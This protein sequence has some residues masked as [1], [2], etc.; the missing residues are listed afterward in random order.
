MLKLSFS[1]DS[2]RFILLKILTKRVINC[3]ILFHF[4]IPNHVYAICWTGAVGAG[5]ALHYSSGSDQMVQLLAAPAPQ[6]WLKMK[7]LCVQYEKIFSLFTFFTTLMSVLDPDLHGSGS[8]RCKICFFYMFRNWFV[9][10]GCFDTGTVCFETD[11][12][13][14]VVSKRVKN[15]K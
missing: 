14:C 8:R 12:F 11:L 5:A 3:V 10:F 15:A 6:P 1:F 2:V 13:V 4:S 7:Q 9:C